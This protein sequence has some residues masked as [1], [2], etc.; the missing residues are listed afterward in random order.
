MQ[1]YEAR[2]RHRPR[3]RDDNGTRGSGEDFS[4]T[5]HFVDQARRV[6]ELLDAGYSNRQIAGH[7]GVSAVRISQIRGRLPALQ[8]YLGTPEPLDRLRC[9]RD[10]L[11]KLRRQALELAAVI[12]RLRPP[13]AIVAAFLVAASCGRDFTG[14]ATHGGVALRPR[15]AHAMA[16]A[17][18]DLDLVRVRL[19]RPP[20]VSEVVLD[21][22]IPRNVDLKDAS[23]DKR[24]IF[25]YAPKS[26][27]AYAYQR[28]IEEVFPA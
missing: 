21:T 26:S 10:Q 2:D 1:T 7:L 22:I 25:S 18:V 11:W 16:N 6:A 13:A 15:F 3:G 14:P 20:G 8:A 23:F 19:Y 24:D 27:A 4:P 5:L 17:L 12:R 28:L 9:H